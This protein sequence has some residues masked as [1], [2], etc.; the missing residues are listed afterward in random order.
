MLLIVAQGFMLA[1][2]SKGSA[3]SRSIAGSPQGTVSSIQKGATDMVVV[4]HASDSVLTVGAPHIL[5][6][7]GYS[8]DRDNVRLGDTVSVQNR[9][10]VDLSR[11]RVSLQGLVATALDPLSAT[12]IVQ[13][14]SGVQIVV[15]LDAAT[16]INGMPATPNSSLLIMDADL[17]QLVGVFDKQIGE[18]TQT[19]SVVYS[20][21]LR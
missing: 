16:R 6:S 12:M 15:D 20:T 5:T 3:P 7:D 1:F 18:M 2:P 10:V 9:Q 19:E 8:L 11:A 13:L 21:P 14:N 17:V 4:Q